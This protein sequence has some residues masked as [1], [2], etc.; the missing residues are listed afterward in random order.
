MTLSLDDSRED[1][2]LKLTRIIDQKLS[3]PES[4]LVKEFLTQYYLAISPYD[5]REKTIDEL[6]GALLS[7]WNFIYK[8]APSESKVRVYNPHLEEHGWQSA[9]TIIEILHINKPFLLDSIRLALNKLDLN[10]RLMIHAEGI[11]FERD[12]NGKITKILPLKI[13]ETATNDEKLPVAEA[14]IYIEV[15][16]VSSHDRLHSIEQALKDILYDVDLMVRDW[17]EMLTKLTD[18]IVALEAGQKQDDKTREVIAFLRWLANDNFTFIGMSEYKITVDSDKNRVMEYIPNTALGVLSNRKT[19]NLT[20]N[21]DKMYPDAA[22]ALLNDDIL[23]LGKTDTL[24]TVH[25]PAYTDFIGIKYFDENGHVAKIVRFLGL[26][27]SSVYNQSVEE[28]PYIRQKIT[29]I[30]EMTLFPKNS[31]DGRSLLHIISTLPRDELFQ[32]R[33]HEL[34]DFA[35]GILHLQERQKIKIFI[36]RDVYGRYFSCLIY[37]PREIFSAQ[38]RNKMQDI[39]MRSLG[40]ISVTFKTQL[41]ESVLARIHFIIRVDQHKNIIYDK[42]FYW[43]CLAICLSTNAYRKCF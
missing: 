11:R 41:S 23:L 6:Y 29:R 35:I 27:T 13:E 25:R 40:G 37:V 9:H 3:A 30:F 4:I 22:L 15:D 33:E 43:S 7:Q 2:I 38:L 19:G 1:L 21:I 28:I 32:A 34:F 14:P 5:L 17:E 20:R 10:V 18:N 26:Y 36:R 39:L 16:K 24:S 12:P 42:G 8:R 31:H